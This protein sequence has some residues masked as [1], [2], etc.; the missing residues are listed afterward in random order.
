MAETR[1][2]YTPVAYDALQL[3]GE[4]VASGLP[5]YIG[6]GIGAA[7][8]VE[9]I[10]TDELSPV[11]ETTLDT[12]VTAHTPNPTN[13]Q[14]RQRDRAKALLDAVASEQAA[15]LRAVVLVTLDEINALRQWVTSFKAA[16][17]A[18]TSLVN[19]QTRVAALSSTPDRT[20]TQARAAIK[21]HL[22]AGDADS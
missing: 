4:I 17:A 11:N 1:Y 18:S 9:V 10:F 19:L 15:L 7:G 5:G 3:E 8:L 14:T 21:S 2:P 12:V 6:L 13:S 16:V 22:D 20:P